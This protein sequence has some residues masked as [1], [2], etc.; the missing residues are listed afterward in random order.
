MKPFTPARLE[1][2]KQAADA[3]LTMKPAINPA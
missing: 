2:L 3:L 1:P